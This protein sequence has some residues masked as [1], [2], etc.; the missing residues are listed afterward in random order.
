VRAKEDDVERSWTD[1]QLDDLKVA[2]AAFEE[3]FKEYTEACRERD[4]WKSVVQ[5]LASSRCQQPKQEARGALNR[6]VPK[7]AT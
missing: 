5:R 4:Y 6:G 1:Q 3:T 7:R 2:R